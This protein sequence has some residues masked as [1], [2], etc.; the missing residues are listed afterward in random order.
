MVAYSFKARFAAPILAGTKPGTIRAD[1]K[2][3]ARQG[4]EMQLYTGM[5]TRSCKLIMRAPCSKVW[6][7]QILLERRPEIIDGPEKVQDLN[8]FAV[9]DGFTDFDEM[10]RF[11]GTTTTRGSVGSAGSICSGTSRARPTRGSPDA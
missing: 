6:P 3:H 7:I 11:S 8:A 2:R 1:R 4:E 10:A 9:S 5:R